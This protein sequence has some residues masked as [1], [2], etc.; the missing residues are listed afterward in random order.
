M[1]QPETRKLLRHV[2]VRQQ[3]IALGRRFHLVFL[4]LA[5]V[6][7]VLLLT[8]RL[9]A[10]I[11]WEFKPTSV[12][13]IPGGALVAAV[14]LWRR[15]PASRTA[16]LIDT[17]M[18]TGDLFLTAA[19]LDRSAGE[20]K[21]LVVRKAEAAAPRI[22][23]RNVAP[24]RWRRKTGHVSA[25]LLMLLAGA[26]LVPQLDPF[27]NAEERN[28]AVERKK[29]LAESRRATALRKQILARRQTGDLSPEV[30]QALQ[31]L[32]RT[33]DALKKQDRTGNLRRLNTG[34]KQLSDLWR[35]RREARLR[36]AL[37][38]TPAAQR[39]GAGNLQKTQQ[40]R[41]QL[42][43]ADST[44]IR[45]ELDELKTL[46]QQLQQAKNPAEQEKLRRE[47]KQ[48]LKDLADFMSD[49]TNSQCMNSAL[50]RALD[51]LGMSGMKGLSSDALQGLQESLNLSQAELD[52]LM[53]S[54]RDTQALENALKAL[55]M[56]KALNTLGECSAGQGC[57]TIE[58]YARLYAELMEKCGGCQ[59]GAGAGLVPGGKPGAGAGM[60]GPGI[61]KGNIAPEDDSVETDFKPEKSRSALHAGKML[62]QWK[63]RGLSDPGEAVEDYQQYVDDVKQGLSEAVLQERVP[64][65]YHETI[66]KYFDTMEEAVGKP[67]G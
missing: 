32:K 29:Q 66:Q 4:V 13:L 53:Q 67:G 19:L 15:F 61:G 23:P 48:R 64:P 59:G 30:S 52:R 8:A 28:R 18:D 3:V 2:S 54:L 36:D 42:R 58:D 43:Q 50:Q 24:L 17:S 10:L 56:C 9:L 60:G 12:L 33:F 25:V 38:E 16:R 34:Q 44:G 45:Q 22:R 31:E 65:G 46:A 1:D 11:P 57:K 51:Q 37:S 14:A 41:R 7:L 62:L 21:P 39:F 20:F 49:E 47:L 40:W 63:Q 6:Y 55:Q 26:L 27:G 35:R 5:A